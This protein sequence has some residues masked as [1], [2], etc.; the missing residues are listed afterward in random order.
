[1]RTTYEIDCLKS[2]SKLS[3]SSPSSHH[4]HHHHH[5]SSHHHAHHHHPSAK[6]YHTS[7]HSSS[8]HHNK[9]SANGSHGLGNGNGVGGNGHQA[10]YKPL[11]P[12]LEFPSNQFDR[13]LHM[14]QKEFNSSGAGKSSSWQRAGA[15]ENEKKKK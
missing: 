7:V 9:S 5:L 4:H 3:I 12:R 6:D 11:L 10:S 14:D 2:F 15:T 13:L 8:H 1:M